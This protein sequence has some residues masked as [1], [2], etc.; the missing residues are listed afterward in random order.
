M[1]SQDSRSDATKAN[2]CRSNF[3]P[4][5]TVRAKNFEESP[6]IEKSSYRVPI[7]FFNS[8]D[9]QIFLKELKTQTQKS[10]E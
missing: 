4:H 10:G 1:K 8:F 9:F 2:T 7:H 6:T 3:Y 5:E